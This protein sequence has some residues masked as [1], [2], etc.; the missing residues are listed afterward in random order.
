M[1]TIDSALI[2]RMKAHAGVFALVSNRIYMPPIPEKSAG[3]NPY[4]CI[5]LWE[6]HG[7]RDM[8]MGGANGLVKGEFQLS[9]F[10]ESFTDSR[11]VAEQVRLCLNGWNGT[12]DG[13]EVDL[14]YLM[15][16]DADPYATH[17][18]SNARWVEQYY[19]VH[20]R[21]ATA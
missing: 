2:T 4:P 21:E 18:P 20:W 3:F 14:V 17:M 13:V 11:A 1:G 15:D 19:T 10:G 9:T 7:K 6:V 5:E 16:E 8:T 12:S